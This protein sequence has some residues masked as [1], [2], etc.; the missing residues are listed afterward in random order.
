M[1]EKEFYGTINFDNT[2][3]FNLDET[4]KEKKTRQ[5]MIYLLI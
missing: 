1:D 4:N 3:T 5:V 2:D